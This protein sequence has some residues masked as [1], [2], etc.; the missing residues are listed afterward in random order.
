ME[1]KDSWIEY[2][3]KKHLHAKNVDVL[4]IYII[5]IIVFKNCNLLIK[6]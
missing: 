3:K 1:Y 6:R 4:N 2:C 5:L